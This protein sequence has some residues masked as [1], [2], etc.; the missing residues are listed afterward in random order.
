MKILVLIIYLL[1]L[2]LF[3]IS[4]GSAEDN[5]TLA[6]PRYG[7]VVCEEQSS[8]YIES[9]TPITLVKS[10][11][12]VT[13]SLPCLHAC[14]I[15]VSDIRDAQGRTLFSGPDR[16][17]GN[18]S[19]EA[20]VYI[21]DKNGATLHRREGNG[22]TSDNFFKGDPLEFTRDNPISIKMFCNFFGKTDNIQTGQTVSYKQKP[23]KLEEAWA[24][25]LEY[26]PITGTEG[27]TLNSV[28]DRYKEDKNIQYL[29]PT[30]GTLEQKPTST[31]TSVAEIPTN[32]KVSDSYIFV[33]DW[34]TGI[35]DISLTYDKQNNGYWCGGLTGSRKTYNVNKVVSAAGSC[36][37]I[38]TSVDKQVECCFPSD[39]SAKGS[40]YTCNPDTW[41][42]EE[43]RWCDSQLDCD[44]VFGKGV[45]QD[46]KITDWSCDTSKKWG[47]HSGTCVKNVRDVKQCASA[48]TGQEYYNE[49][50]GICKP[51]SV[52]LDC[53]A[54]SCCSE[55]GNYKPSPCSDDLTCCTG[56][57]SKI[58]S[59]KQSCVATQ[60]PEAKNDFVST[61]PLAEV[62]NVGGLGL[63]VII[64]GGSIIGVI[65]LLFFVLRKPKGSDEEDF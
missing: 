12:E 57:D 28:I 19:D 32:W 25:S 37:S 48:C 45:C 41:K 51:R 65:A 4:N 38:P 22:D 18:T 20:W 40:G 53:P 49:E 56:G 16:P 59:C 58:G 9:I 31:Y 14:Q 29:D 60:Q 43:T 61:K 6:I 23:I 8:S 15:S 10:N 13:A 55:G 24:G 54:G 44:Q 21:L 47:S 36:Y 2:T 50:E 30:K 11:K 3:L 42:C 27:C 35:A 1:I 64:G 62:S 63:P 52:I 46:N 34:Q 7:S 5:C 33:K 26:V 39:C 17:C